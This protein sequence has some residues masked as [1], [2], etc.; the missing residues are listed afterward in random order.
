MAND[1]DRDKARNRHAD[2]G[3]QS[4]SGQATRGGLLGAVGWLLSQLAPQSLLTIAVT[5][6]LTVVIVVTIETVILSDKGE[7][8]EP[9][10]DHPPKGVGPK[11]PL[12][13][14]E[15]EDFVRLLKADVRLRHLP[16][17]DP[18]V[19]S[20][21]EDVDDEVGDCHDECIEERH[22]HDYPIVPPE[23][24][25]H[26]MSADPVDGEYLLNNE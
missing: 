12:T 20:G 6:S 16:I 24:G 25:G 7:Q 8:G 9:V 11:T 13:A 18:R 3:D 1:A 15:D 26:E 4:R 14:V 5:F 17:P 22:S 2:E 21:V 10:A 23:H 19:D